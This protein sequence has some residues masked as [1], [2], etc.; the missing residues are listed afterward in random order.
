MVGNEKFEQILKVGGFSLNWLERILAK[1]EHANMD[2]EVQNWAVVGK[3][4]WRTDSSL[5]E[6]RVFVKCCLLSLLLLF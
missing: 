3:R 5:V 2:T 6:G 4:A 1:P